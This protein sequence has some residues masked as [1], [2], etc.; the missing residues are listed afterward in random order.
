MD[1]VLLVG[2]ILSPTLVAASTHPLP[3]VYLVKRLEEILVNRRLKIKT[4]GLLLPAN[5]YKCDHLTICNYCKRTYVDRCT[6]M[7]R[8][9][10]PWSRLLL[11]NLR[12][13]GSLSYEVAN[14]GKPSDW[15]GGY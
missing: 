12:L 10:L 13:Y 5:N 6:C 8:T 15:T 1:M 9:N 4:N 7:G 14:S 2:G 11:L 3:V